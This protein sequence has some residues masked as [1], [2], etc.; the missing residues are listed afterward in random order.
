MRKLSIQCES[1]FSERK[2]QNARHHTVAVTRQIEHVQINETK[3]EVE[4]TTHRK[5]SEVSSTAE[6]QRNDH[7]ARLAPPYERNRT[8]NETEN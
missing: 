7:K 5:S 1:K 4:T 8:Q 6:I 3:C 2:T